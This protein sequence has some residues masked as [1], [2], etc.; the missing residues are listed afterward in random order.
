MRDGRS[1]MTAHV[2]ASAR[3]FDCCCVNSV[4][5]FS[6]GRGM[7]D[8]M[9]IF[10]TTIAIENSERRGP[11]QEL[12]DTLV[13]TG[14]EFT[15]VPRAVLETLEIAPVRTQRFVVADGRVLEREIG[16]AIVHAGGT[17]APDLVVFAEGGDMVLLG[18]HSLEGL[19]M[20]IDPVHKQ[21]VPAGPI[22]TAN[23]GW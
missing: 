12:A 7:M 23:A 19:N 17:M 3:Q 15:W 6:T 13:D 1:G 20:H 22:V 14:S 2:T 10:R 18:A 16:F 8:D 21:L 5:L 11:K 9:G 4:P